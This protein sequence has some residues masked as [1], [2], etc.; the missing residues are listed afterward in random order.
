MLAVVTIERVRERGKDT[1]QVRAQNG[2][3]IVV[4]NFMRPETGKN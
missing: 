4:V 3:Q 1:A 2:S